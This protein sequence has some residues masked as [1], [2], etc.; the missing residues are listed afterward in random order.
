[1]YKKINFENAIKRINLGETI[2]VRANDGSLFPVDDIEDNLIA[3]SKYDYYREIK[4]KDCP[5][6]GSDAV[7]YKD[8]Y[9]HYAIRCSS[10]S[11]HYMTHETEE[12][13][14]NVWNKEIGEQ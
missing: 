6:C 1:M 8:K 5:D 4:I 14:V 13:A 10:C 7:L 11:C 2:L 3:F 12:W 9:N